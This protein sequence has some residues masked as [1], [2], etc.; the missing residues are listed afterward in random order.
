MKT[1]QTLSAIL[2]CL[3]LFIQVPTSCAQKTRWEKRDKWQN[4][5]AIFEAMAVQPGSQV[6]DIGARDG[7]L[8][9]RLV[10]A[11]GMQGR[12]YAVDINA[13][14][15]ETLRDNLAAEDTSR[16]VLVHSEPDDPMLAEASLDAAVVVNA[17]HEFEA[18][19]AMLKHIKAALKPGGRLVLVE[20][21][22]DRRRDATRKK[23]MSH[24]E[25]GINYARA[26]LEDAGFEVLDAQDPFVERK[27]QSDKMWLI[28]GR[29]P[30]E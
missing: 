9:I 3:V 29:K 2:G 6:A 28:V 14:S 26:D 17:Y 10:E 22:T 1:K 16:V 21:I 8:T 12:V 23:Q 15:L 24:H 5:P 30:V 13:K 18:Y 19:K 7:Y 25:I 27:D 4:V 11:V 20:P